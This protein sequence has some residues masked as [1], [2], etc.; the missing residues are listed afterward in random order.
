MPFAAPEQRPHPARVDG[1]TYTLPPLLE[2]QLD[3]EWRVTRHWGITDAM[4]KNKHDQL[5]SYRDCSNA[6]TLYH[7]D[8]DGHL[9]LD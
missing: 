6:Q 8:T 4:D 5:F 2:P 3:H 1:I 7:Y 9:Y